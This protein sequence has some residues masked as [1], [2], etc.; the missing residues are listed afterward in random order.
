MIA[1]TL[2]LSSESGLRLPC[3]VL[4]YIL[5]V[6]L[7]IIHLWGSRWLVC[8]VRS[9]LSRQYALRQISIG[10]NLSY[11]LWHHLSQYI[12]C[13]L[14]YCIPSSQCVSFFWSSSLKLSFSPFLFLFLFLKH[15]HIH[16]HTH[17]HTQTFIPLLLL[18]HPQHATE[19]KEDFSLALIIRSFS[20][21]L[22]LPIQFN[23]ETTNSLCTTVVTRIWLQCPHCGC[24]K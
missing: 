10:L 22:P 15:T 3:V 24:Q 16:T 13:M 6:V 20:R 19:S 23:M 4:N 18:Q 9:H 11:C 21:R 12:Y 7:Q 17:T 1:S 8:C 14:Q 5:C 2:L